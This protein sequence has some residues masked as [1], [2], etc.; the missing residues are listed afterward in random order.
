MCAFKGVCNLE[1]G[2]LLPAV[3]NELESNWQAGGCEA[4]W[5]RDGRNSREVCWTVQPQQA[6][7]DLFVFTIDGDFF[8]ADLCGGKRGSGRS[9]YVEQSREIRTVI[10]ER[11]Q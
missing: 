4:A 1:E 8:G 7:S 2:F 11:N 3:A 9:D 5:H 10:E 6:S